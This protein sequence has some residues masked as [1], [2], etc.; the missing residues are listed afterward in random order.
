MIICA[1]KSNNS[2]KLLA[3]ARRFKDGKLSEVEL[4][5]WNTVPRTLRVFYSGGVKFERKFVSFGECCKFIFA[6]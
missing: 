2:E 1:I 6:L 5:D 3:I 4:C